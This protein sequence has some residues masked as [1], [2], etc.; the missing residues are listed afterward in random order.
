[1]TG[2]T[3]KLGLTAH[4]VSSVGWIGAV[5]ASVALAVLALVAEPGVVDAAYIAME[6]IALY[7]LVPLS[8]LSLATGVIQG[9][10]TKWGV[11]HHYWVVIKLCINVI[12]SI[13]LLLYT[14]TLGA[15][16][17]TAL[18]SYSAAQSDPSPLLHSGIAL[19]L[20]T[21]AAGLSVYKPRG[22]TRYGWRKQQQARQQP[23]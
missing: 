17:D 9:L 3:R 19:V 6:A 20:L 13:V 22:R 11:L 7:V 16:A 5:M 4:I 21:C 23:I 10:G 15:F 14:Q 2:A 12:S 8:L 18:E 1:M